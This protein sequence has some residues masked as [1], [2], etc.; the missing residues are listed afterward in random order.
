MLCATMASRR[1][2]G[3]RTAAPTA[4]APDRAGSCASRNRASRRGSRPPAA[5]TAAADSCRES[6]PAV[7]GGGA[8][9]SQSFEPAIDDVLRIEPQQVGRRGRGARRTELRAHDAGQEVDRLGMVALHALRLAGERGQHARIRP[10]RRPPLSSRRAV[11]LA[12]SCGQL[13]VVAAQPIVDGDGVGECCVHASDPEPGARMAMREP[14]PR[15]R[16]DRRTH[17]RGCR[18]P[19]SM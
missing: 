9:K 5:A 16:A 14:A 3:R 18:M 10:H 2:P 19:R 13:L 11:P 17:R 4:P 12:S 7:Q 1:A 8:G 15:A 6:P